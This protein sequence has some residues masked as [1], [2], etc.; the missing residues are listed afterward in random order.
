MIVHA[1]FCFRLYTPPQKNMF[2]PWNLHSLG[3]AILD[4][5]DQALGVDVSSPRWK[6]I[7]RPG[8]VCREPSPGR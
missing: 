2:Y 4:H 5:L 3:V 7:S 6:Q 1:S 8:M